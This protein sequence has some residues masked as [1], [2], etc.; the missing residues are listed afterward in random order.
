VGKGKKKEGRE[1]KEESTNS[2][3][4]TIPFSFAPEQKRK[5]GKK[6]KSTTLFYG[7]AHSPVLS[8]AILRHDPTHLSKKKKKKGGK[9]VLRSVHLCRLFGRG[10]KGAA[11]REVL[12]SPGRHKRDRCTWST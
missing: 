7:L 9:N 3:V 5:E 6:K 1:K 10:E 8:S 2:L 12:V 4:T 11:I